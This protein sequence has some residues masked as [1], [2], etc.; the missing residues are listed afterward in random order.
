MWTNTGLEAEAAESSKPASG[1]VGRGRAWAD[2]GGHWAG[3]AGVRLARGRRRTFAGAAWN[4][5]EDRLTLSRSPSSS[6]PPSLVT[7]CNPP[8]AMGANLSK[9]LGASTRR[10][11]PR[12]YPRRGNAGGCLDRVTRPTDTLFALSREALW[13]QG[14]AAVDVGFGRGRKDK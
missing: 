3:V 12:Q 14:D 9:A 11:A 7:Y 6:H 4:A 1:A 13:K 10:C 8:P 2:H 5:P